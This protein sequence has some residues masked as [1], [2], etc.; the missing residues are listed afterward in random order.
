MKINIIA[1]IGE[2]NQIGL[3]G[4]LPWNISEDMAHFRSITTGHTVI[5]GRN[6]YEAIGRPLPNR[7]N[8]V[9]TSRP[10][11]AFT[12]TITVATLLDQALALCSNNDTVYIIG[13]ERLYSEAL[14]LAERLIIT[15][16]PYAG[17]ADSFFPSIDPTLWHAE[18]E[19]RVHCSNG[20]HVRF[21]CYVRS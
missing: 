21:V 13:G 17:P 6:T 9:V 1:A 19:E 3:N 7:R 11:G 2:S 20:T 16:V 5:M 14:S 8:I 18:S 10:Q 4:K 12:E 15:H